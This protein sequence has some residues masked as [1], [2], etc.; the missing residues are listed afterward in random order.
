MSTRIQ[1]IP[2][3]LIRFTDRIR[4]QAWTGTAVDAT[5]DA[6]AMEPIRT[7]DFLGALLT[8]LT[9]LEASLFLMLVTILLFMPR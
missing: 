9:Y 4:I 7:T 5:V 6:L 1:H 3:E 8:S 2:Q